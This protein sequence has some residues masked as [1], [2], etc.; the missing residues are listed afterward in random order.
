MSWLRIDDAFASHP[1]IEALT[2]A[3]FVVWMRVLCHVARYDPNTGI[4]RR[5]RSNRSQIVRGFTPNRS[6]K[7]H[8]TGLLDLHENGTDFVV[9]DWSDYNGNLVDKRE[10]DAERQR[11][12][13]DKNVTDSSAENVTARDPRVR[14]AL[15]VPSPALPQAAEATPPPAITDRETAAALIEKLD[16]LN[17]AGG[18]RVAALQDP[19]RALACAEKAQTSAKGNPA[20]YF[21][22]LLESGDNPNPSATEHRPYYPPKDPVAAI[23]KQITNGAIPDL[24]TLNAELDALG[25]NGA[26]AAELRTLVPA[27]PD[28]DPSDDID[29]G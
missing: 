13:R 25:I 18:L 6:R 16:E 11:R 3:E 4:V 2:D 14:A 1:K 24:V 10:K 9:H 20:G 29:F 5:S 23:Q 28:T 27:E 7:Y 8:E 17:I 19:H 21:R 22:K 26:T 12:H 15:P